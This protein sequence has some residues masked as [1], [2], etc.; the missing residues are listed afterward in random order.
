MT[1]TIVASLALSWLLAVA[2]CN[3]ANSGAAGGGR[4]NPSQPE[5]GSPAAQLQQK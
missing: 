3:A 2:A 4:A 1:R 5:P